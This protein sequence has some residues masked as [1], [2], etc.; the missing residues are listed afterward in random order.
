M[1]NVNNSHNQHSN[2]CVTQFVWLHTTRTDSESLIV[3]LVPHRL[4]AFQFACTFSIFFCP[5]FSPNLLFHATRRASIFS[6]FY[7]I[8]FAT[9]YIW[10]KTLLPQSECQFICVGCL[11]A[12][13]MHVIFTSFYFEWIIITEIRVK[14]MH[15]W[16]A[17]SSNAHSIIQSLA[18]F[19]STSTNWVHWG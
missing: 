14:C 8:I 6:V 19:F 18:S 1:C 15:V 16:R 7:R 5:F 9:I 2:A 11:D 13:K 3:N 17:T 4:I 12:I 10:N